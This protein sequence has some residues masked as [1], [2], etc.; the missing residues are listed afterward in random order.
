MCFFRR[1]WRLVQPSP[2]P[3]LSLFV[4]FLLGWLMGNG[5]LA[6]QPSLSEAQFRKL[7]RETS[8][9][10]LKE[11]NQRYA[12]SKSQHPSLEENRRIAIAKEG[13]E[14]FVTV[15]SCADSR[16][17][18]EL[19]FDRGLGELF[20]VRV[21]GNVAGV[22]ELASIEYGVGHLHTPILL[23]LGHSK[24]GAVTAAAK[25]AALHGHLPS[26]VAN[27]RPAV[28]RAKDVGGTDVV[29][30]AI[31]ENVWQ[32]INDIITK[33]EVIQQCVKEGSVK[34]IGALYDIDSGKVDWLGEHPQMQ[35]L[36]EVSVP[37][38][39]GG[40]AASPKNEESHAAVA[41]PIGPP[42]GHGSGN[43]PTTSNHEA[44]VKGNHGAAGEHAEP[45]HVPKPPGH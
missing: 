26:L 18:P 19:L 21:A 4:V 27:I 28:E 41:A 43:A 40:H 34:V 17:P 31:R 38:P 9:L 32:A 30:S 6:A 29:S 12:T 5:V 16:V 39:T 7:Y 44:P 35:N 1:S 45:A 22:D 10:L 25:G 37:A 36:L 24:C 13:Q 20:V 33:S 3:I 8:L 42:G 14:P 23:V 2:K 15:L 11:G